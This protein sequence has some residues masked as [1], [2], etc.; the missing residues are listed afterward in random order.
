MSY[1]LQ[2]KPNKT[3]DQMNPNRQKAIKALLDPKNKCLA[4]VAEATGLHVNTLIKYC[5]EEDFLKIVTDA[6]KAING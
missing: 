5:S 4:D 2:S 3:M 6:K 1:T